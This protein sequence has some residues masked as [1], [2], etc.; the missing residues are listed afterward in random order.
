MPVNCSLAGILCSLAVWHRHYHSHIHSPTCNEIYRESIKIQ[1]KLR[2]SDVSLKCKKCESVTHLSSP[3]LL[4]IVT[5]TYVNEGRVM[6]ECDGVDIE[7]E[8]LEVVAHADLMHV[9]LVRQ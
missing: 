5:L 6:P 7:Q 9:H 8:R 4:H 1:T 2:T 3:L